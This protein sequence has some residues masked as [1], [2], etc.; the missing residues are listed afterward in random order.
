MSELR[1]RLA[2]RLP[3]AFGVSGPLGTPLVSRRRTAGL[4]R[5]ALSE[6]ISLFDTAPAYGAGEAERRLGAALIQAGADAFVMTKAGLTSA[7]LSRRIR[8]FSPGA[9]RAGVEASADR[10]RRRPVDLLWLHGPAPAE[11]TPA[12]SACLDTLVRDGLVRHVGVA[13]R[14]HVGGLL[15]RHP[16]AA[17]MLPIHAGLDAAGRSGVAAARRAGAMV[18]AIE[19]MAPARLPASPLSGPGGLWRLARRLRAGAGQAPAGILSPQDCL[20]A[21]FALGA[22]MI[23]TST[24]WPERIAANAA[25]VRAWLES[26]GQAL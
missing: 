23:V 16:F 6:G 20:N 2:G 12:L 19:V 15:A 17:V 1:A 3:L 13:T 9:I 10:L 22:E 7:G 21:A 26:G 25:S 8:D 18:F 24:T 5:A 11:I 4:V 14:S